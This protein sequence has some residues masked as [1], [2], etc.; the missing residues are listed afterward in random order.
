MRF[1]ISTGR[2]GRARALAIAC[3]L[4]GLLGGAAL[5]GPHGGGPAVG[6]MPTG[7]MS[8]VN[9]GFGGRSA[10]NVSPMGLANRNGPGAVDRDFGRDRAEDRRS[11]MARGHSALTSNRVNGVDR[12]FGR[13]RAEDRAHRH[14]RRHHKPG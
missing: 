12:D 8:G 13:D 3:A 7:G 10:G 1:E 11:A 14:H 2:Q 4:G 5:A 6:G 9:G